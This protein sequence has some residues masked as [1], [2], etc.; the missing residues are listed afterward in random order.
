M[1][2]LALNSKS[3]SNIY[4]QF[5]KELALKQIGN[6]ILKILKIAGIALVFIYCAIFYFISICLGA[7]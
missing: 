1:E 5:E 3:K 7:K 6:S 2:Q 4:K